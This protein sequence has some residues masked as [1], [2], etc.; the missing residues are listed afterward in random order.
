MRQIQQFKDVIALWPT[1]A[2]FGRDIGIHEVSARAM[3][4]RNSIPSKYWEKVIQSAE[5]RGIMTITHELLAQ[6]AAN[7]LSKSNGHRK[8]K[9]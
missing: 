7:P 2:E 4:Q 8:N 3:K 6:F 1:A 9:T 5:N